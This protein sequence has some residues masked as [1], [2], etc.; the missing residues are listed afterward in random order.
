[1]PNGQATT[2]AG[3]EPPEPHWSSCRKAMAT[4]V[5]EPLQTF[6]RSIQQPA[7][8]VHQR[9]SVSVLGCAL[10]STPKFTNRVHWIAQYPVWRGALLVQQF[11]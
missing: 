8:R 1:M 6:S 4:L 2:R 5:L 10:F 9:Q 11:D 3:R 7:A